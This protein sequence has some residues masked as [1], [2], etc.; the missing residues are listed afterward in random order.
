[1]IF[2][3]SVYRWAYG[4]A[5][6]VG[7]YKTEKEAQDAAERLRETAKRKGLD[8]TYIVCENND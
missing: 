5:E 6:C 3:W 8:N 7:V 4:H 2:T 1:M